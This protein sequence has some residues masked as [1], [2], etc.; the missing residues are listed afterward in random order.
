VSD[1]VAQLISTGVIGAA[2]FQ[3][4]SL[5]KY[6]MK[7]R[8]LRYAIDHGDDRTAVKLAHELKSDRLLR[9][10]RPDVKTMT[11]AGQQ[12]E[13]QPSLPSSM[14]NST[15][16]PPGDRSPAAP[17]R[18]ARRSPTAASPGP[19]PPRPHQFREAR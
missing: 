1:Y 7:I 16:R 4:S 11:R 6:R 10:S 9:L 3:V 12:R 14:S 2:V 19:T 17:S 18:S 8:L 5:V 15:V 13:P